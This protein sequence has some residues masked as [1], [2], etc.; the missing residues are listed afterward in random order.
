MFLE[1][2]GVFTKSQA[3]FYNFTLAGFHN[4]NICAT[5]IDT[6]RSI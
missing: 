5:E 4:F 3:L 1:C 6:I 2:S